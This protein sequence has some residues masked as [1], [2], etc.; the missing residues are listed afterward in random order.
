MEFLKSITLI[1]FSEMTRLGDQCGYAEEGR[2]ENSLSM[3]KRGK[4]LDQ[5]RGPHTHILGRITREIQAYT[6]VCPSKAEAARRDGSWHISAVLGL[7]LTMRKLLNILTLWRKPAQQTRMQW[8]LK[9]L[10]LQFYRHSWM[11]S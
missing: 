11:D 4:N 2:T 7:L 6:L 3:L 10:G 9:D 5:G 1:L 8:N